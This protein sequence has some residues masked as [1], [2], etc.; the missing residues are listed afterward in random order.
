MSDWTPRGHAAPATEP[1]GGNQWTARVA[2]DLYL[3]SHDSRTGRALLEPRTLGLGLAAGLVAELVL[4]GAAQVR[5]GRLVAIRH[6][7]LSCRLA[8]RVRGQIAAEPE[9][10]PL[11]DWLAFLARQARRDVACRLEQ[12]RHLTRTGR[13]LPWRRPRPLATDPAWAFAPLVRVRYALGSD[14]PLYPHEAMLAGL[15]V[16]CGLWSRVSQYVTPAGRGLD[17][18]LIQLQ[19]GLRELIS[20]TQALVDSAVLSGRA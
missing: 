14:R 8:S 11:R 16:A 7:P 17:E 20:Q 3:L 2:D 4:A 9:P 6:I 10:H 13:S 5:T 18:A 15:A 19:P 1:A 12:H